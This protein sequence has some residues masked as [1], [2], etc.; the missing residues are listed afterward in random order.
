MSAIHLITRAR[1]EIPDN[2]NVVAVDGD[3]D[4][5]ADTLV[6]FHDP[7][8]LGEG[9][10]FFHITPKLEDENIIINNIFPI[11][12]VVIEGTQEFVTYGHFKI[13]KNGRAYGY[14]SLEKIN[15]DIW[16]V[17][18]KEPEA[19]LYRLY[20]CCYGLPLEQCKFS[21]KLIIETNNVIKYLVVCKEDMDGRA[22]VEPYLLLPTD[23]VAEFAVKTEDGKTWSYKIAWNNR[24]PAEI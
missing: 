22:E 12:G 19:Y 14:L 3:N 15:Y 20:L 10:T 8:S 13:R 6:H 24:K 23:K 21:N 1:F 18:D 9:K 11:G 4:S 5:P 7:I 16:M 17:S 2:I